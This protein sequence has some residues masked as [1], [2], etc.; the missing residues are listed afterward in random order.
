M[1]CII[2]EFIK[3]LDSLVA[4]E[5]MT[6]KDKAIL[7]SIGEYT[8]RFTSAIPADGNRKT[9]TPGKFVNHSGGALGADTYWGDI[10]KAFGVTSN[11][12]YKSNSD[13]SKP[14]EGNTE[15]TDDEYSVGVRMAK[16]AHKLLNGDKKFATNSYTIGLLARNWVQVSNSDAVY[17]VA[18][19]DGEFVN[20]GTGYAVAMATIASKP[21]FVF[22]P[23]DNQWY[24]K[25][26]ENVDT[27]KSV[28]DKLDAAPTLTQNFAGIGTRDIS[29]FSKPTKDGN[30]KIVFAPHGKYNEKEAIN[31]INAIKDAYNATFGDKE[32]AIAIK[33]DVA[34][35]GK[36]LTPLN[37][38]TQDTIV[39]IGKG[40]VYSNPFASFTK[41]DKEK[42]KMN[43]QFIYWLKKGIPEGYKINKAVE[44]K[45]S[46]IRQKLNSGEL[47]NAVFVQKQYGNSPTEASM[48]A[49]YINSKQSSIPSI[50]LDKKLKVVNKSTNRI[51]WKEFVKTYYIGMKSFSKTNYIDKGSVDVDGNYNANSTEVH[52]DA[53]VGS[54]IV[55]NTDSE[56]LYNSIHYGLSEDIYNTFVSKVKELTGKKSM[57]SEKVITEAVNGYVTGSS[58]QEVR[59]VLFESAEY[60][61]NYMDEEPLAKGMF[62]INDDTAS[63][64]YNTVEKQTQDDISSLE[65]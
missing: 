12:Y 45:L 47:D 21:I 27:D 64:G 6:D 51:N 40:S 15:I 26:Y 53:R 5:S 2:E 11:H 29:D 60:T 24:K 16:R 14:S 1:A 17:A 8:T 38:G 63:I 65:C 25:N 19:L 28:W 18:E 31:A 39:R 7:N 23:R 20:G 58:I 55:K 33:S 48:L 62:D 13:K 41:D 4:M 32:S 9:T 34:V 10:G 35:E 3:S 43:K 52:K 44:S 22:S 36:E 49:D 42:L 54:F 56:K 50:L 37:L 30:G 59:R 46:L 57:Y 61:M